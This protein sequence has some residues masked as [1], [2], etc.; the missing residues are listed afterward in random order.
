MTSNVRLFSKNG[1]YPQRVEKIRLLDGGT[2][3]DSSTFTS[4]E[5]SLSG[6]TGP[7]YEPQYNEVTQEL[8]WDS[9]NL[10]FIIKDFD[11]EYWLEVLRR[12]RSELLFRSDWTILPDSPLTAE[13]QLEWKEYRQKLRD[14][15][16]TVSFPLP[17]TEEEAQSIFPLSPS[18]E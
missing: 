17:T 16:S 8:I 6:Y 1:E 11:N 13:K 5:I 10:K 12:R 18:L 2:R 15:P 4:E 9:E 14:L 3:T 7:Y